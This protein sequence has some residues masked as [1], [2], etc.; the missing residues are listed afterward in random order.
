MVGKKCA[1][2]LLVYDLAAQQLDLRLADNVQGG[3]R[4]DTGHESPS[5]A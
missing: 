1:E 5:V 2:R 4:F 3:L